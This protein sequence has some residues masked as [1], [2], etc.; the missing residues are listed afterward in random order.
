M[1]SM[2]PQVP[3]FRFLAP[4]NDPVLS[5][6]MRRAAACF[7]AGVFVL[8]APARASLARANESPDDAFSESVRELLDQLET[9]GNVEIDN[10]ELVSRNALPA[11]YS[12]G[13]YKAFWTPERLATLLELVRDSAGDGLHPEDYH[14]SA[15][16]R[17]APAAAS[18]FAAD[19]AARARLDLLATDGFYLLLYHLYVGKVDPK[20]LEP[21]WNF[22]PRPVREPGG[23]RFVLDA[24]TQGRLREAVKQVRPDHWWYERARAALTEYR[25]LAAQGGWQTIPPGKAI[26]SGMSDKRVVAVRHRLAV[27][28]ELSG[29]SLD[30][31]EFDEPLAKAVAAFQAKHRLNADGSV[32]ATTLAELNVPV[33]ARIRQIRVNLERARW[34]LQEITG[35]NLVVVDIAGFEVDYLRDKSMQWKSRI[36]VGKPYRQTPIFKSNIDH[37]VFNPTWTV[38]P[39]IFAKDSLPAVKRDPSYLQKK[40]LDVIDSAG[41]KVDPSTIDW[42]KMTASNFPY[43]LR[44]EPGPDNALGRVKI[45]FPNKYLV[46]LHDTPSKELFEKEERAFS[47]GCMRVERPLELAKLLLDDEQKWSTKE[48]DQ[49]VA[50]GQTRTVPLRQPVPVLIMYWTIDPSVEG[51][52][53]FKRDPYKRDPKLAQA[54]D[55]PFSPGE[56][57]AP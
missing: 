30:S 6:A 38:P 57:R 33:E 22:D 15:L 51:R 24:L 47:S 7:F 40:G 14:L 50:T 20:S 46:Y 54:L 28:G 10:A 55:A 39:G 26:K 27:T 2:A 56:R 23:I 43:M 8:L 19:P 9:T 34:V 17:L 4:L 1:G 37:I 29:E 44:Q 35:G 49:V 11:I 42:S 12:E 25:K 32:G 53:G 48:I 16:E 52:V 18:S 31:P 36:Q 21:T 41:K 5:R 13:G 3:S 45:M